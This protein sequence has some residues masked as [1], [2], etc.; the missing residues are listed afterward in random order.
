MFC[1]RVPDPVELCGHDDLGVLVDAVVERPAHAEELGPLGLGQEAERDL[2][3]AQG[4]LGSPRVHHLQLKVLGG[5]VLGDGQEALLEDGLG[6]LVLDVGGPELAPLRVPDHALGTRGALA[7]LAQAL[8]PL[9]QHG[10]HVRVELVLRGG[11]G[12]GVN[13]IFHNDIVLG[14]Y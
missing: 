6:S 1:S 4:G 7:R 13:N 5:E 11:R 12:E 3:A 8:A 10:H 9:H 2:A 14:M